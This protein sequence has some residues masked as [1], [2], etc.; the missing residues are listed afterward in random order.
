MVIN[1]LWA[2]IRPSFVPLHSSC[3]SK[4]FFNPLLSI[5]FNS[6]KMNIVSV[7]LTRT[8]LRR[9]WKWSQNLWKNHNVP[10]HVKSRVQSITHITHYRFPF[11]IHYISIVPIWFLLFSITQVPVSLSGS[12]STRL[13]L[14]YNCWWIDFIVIATR[15][16]GN[17]WCFHWFHTTR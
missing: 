16:M 12:S 13:W 2:P 15:V 10:L 9:C 6:K 17:T 5:F 11:I 3:T 7:A 4:I 8:T 1:W 14:N